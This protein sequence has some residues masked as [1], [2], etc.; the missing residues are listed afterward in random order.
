MVDFMIGRMKST[1][2]EHISQEPG[3]VIRIHQAEWEEGTGSSLGGGWY[4]NSLGVIEKCRL[5]GDF[6]NPPTDSPSRSLSIHSTPGGNAEQFW[7]QADLNWSPV[8][9][10]AT[11]SKSFNFS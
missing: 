4:Q 7:S 5:E 1:L 8:P 9:C 10:C 6:G 11:L 2:P 3:P